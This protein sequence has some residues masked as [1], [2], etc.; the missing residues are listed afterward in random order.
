[1]RLDV[2][3]H[4]KLNSTLEDSQYCFKHHI[5]RDGLKRE[6]VELS[7]LLLDQLV[8]VYRSLLG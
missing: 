8:K 3:Q 6:F 4:F 2:T 1:M 5:F 7:W